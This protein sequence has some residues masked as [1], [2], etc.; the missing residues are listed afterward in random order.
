MIHPQHPDLIGAMLDW[1]ERRRSASVAA[2]EPASLRVWAFERDGVRSAAY[3][4]R[5]YQRSETC[6]CHRGR[7]LAGQLPEQPLPLGYEVRQLAGPEELEQRVEVHRAAFAPSRMTVEKHR[8]A[9]AAPTYRIDLDLVVVAPDDSFAAFCIVWFDPVSRLGLF[10]PVGCHPAHQR[11]GLARA[12]LCEGMRRLAALGA[13][14]AAVCSLGGS[15]APSGL[16]ESVGLT[17]LDYNW[18]WSK[19]LPPPEE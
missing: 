16:Y 7:A 6:L 2:G 12:V 5:G 3:Q 19:T 4:R 9:M 15:V 11:R 14:S 13:T 17:V 8:R 1:S 10:E 18:A